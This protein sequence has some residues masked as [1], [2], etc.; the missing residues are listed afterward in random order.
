[1]SVPKSILTDH[2]FLSHMK[3]EHLDILAE[4][5]AAQ[6]IEPGKVIFRENELADRFFLIL[7]G[8]VELETRSNKREF[9]LQN[10]GAGEALGWSW[11]FPP[12]GLN[13]TFASAIARPGTV[14]FISQL[15]L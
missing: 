7:D 3:D 5:A 15:V 8:R 2:P 10:V 6:T 14:A 4:C 11:L 13:A 9:P 1:M 12:L